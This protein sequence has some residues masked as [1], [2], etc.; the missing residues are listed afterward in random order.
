MS[1]VIT[2]CPLGTVSPGERHP[3]PGSLTRGRVEATVSGYSRV[4][5]SICWEPAWAQAERPQPVPEALWPRILHW[6]SWPGSRRAVNC[7]FQGS[8]NQNCEPRSPTS[9]GASLRSST[10]RCPHGALSAGSAQTSQRCLMV[11]G[12]ASRGP[13]GVWPSRPGGAPGIEAWGPGVLLSPH[14]AQVTS[15][16]NDAA[17]CC[18]WTPAAPRFRDSGLQRHRVMPGCWQGP[19]PPCGGWG[20]QGHGALCPR[21]LGPELLHGLRA[22]GGEPC[23]RG[24]AVLCRKGWGEGADTAAFPLGPFPPR[25]PRV[26]QQ[27]GGMS[28]GSVA[29][30]LGLPG[31]WFPA[32]S[33]WGWRRAER[34]GPSFAEAGPVSRS[35]GRSGFRHTAGLCHME[36]KPSSAAGTG[37]SVRSRDFHGRVPPSWSPEVES[38]PAHSGP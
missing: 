20:S 28:A 17:Q 13:G 36:R 33:G 7:A 8:G 11:G 38:R 18:V 37:S 9:T 12:S 24:A 31:S 30:C 25:Q 6:V 14:S 26:L 23:E 34:S 3:S 2:W 5:P 27:P 10:R 15:P 16:E 22:Q 1:S 29:P 21:D 35:S 4:S 32:S 19:R